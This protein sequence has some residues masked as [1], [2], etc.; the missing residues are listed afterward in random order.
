MS[1]LDVDQIAKVTSLLAANLNK[2]EQSSPQMISS[3]EQLKPFSALLT[4]DGASNVRRASLNDQQIQRRQYSSAGR[5]FCTFC[6]KEVCN[7][8][9]LRTHM[10]KMHNIVIDENK[11]VIGNIDTLEK[12]RLGAGISVSFFIEI[13]Y[14]T[15]FTVSFRCEFCLMELQSRNE[16]RMHKEEVHGQLLQ[17]TTA[18]NNEQQPSLVEHA[19]SIELLGSNG[20]QKKVN[21]I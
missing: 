7:K 20:N 16:L 5:N 17:S 3:A 19:I 4:A 13:F 21:K 11:P 6:N 12:E 9:F 14:K 18:K 1:N 10:L 15:Y 2:N 8:Y